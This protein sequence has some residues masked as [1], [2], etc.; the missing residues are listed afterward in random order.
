MSRDA[1]LVVRVGRAIRTR[2]AIPHGATRAEAKSDV[3]EA[4]PVV[5]PITHQR[6]THGMAPPRGG[7]VRT[8]VGAEQVEDDPGAPSAGRTVLSGWKVA[9]SAV[10]S[11]ESSVLSTQSGRA[12]TGTA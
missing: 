7:R 5:R 12:G 11:T 3:I 1:P 4:L 8:I 9:G 2:V 10:G 6:I